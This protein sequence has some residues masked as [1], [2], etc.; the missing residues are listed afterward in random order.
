MKHPTDIPITACSYCGNGKVPGEHT[1][2]VLR[3]EREALSIPR[4]SKGADPAMGL[5]HHLGLSESYVFDLEADKRRFTWALVERYRAAL[6]AA[7]VARAAKSSNGSG[8]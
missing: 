6:V 8:K 2:A 4:I 7:T 3:A 5:A 1:G